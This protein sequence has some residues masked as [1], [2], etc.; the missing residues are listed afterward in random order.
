MRRD[1]TATLAVA[2]HH[3]GYDFVLHAHR[4]RIG[5]FVFRR[6]VQENAAQVQIIL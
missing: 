4:L 6:I 2:F 5:S 1:H 3:A